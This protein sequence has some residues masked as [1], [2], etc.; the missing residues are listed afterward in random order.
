MLVGSADTDKRGR[1]GTSVYTAAKAAVRA[2]ARP[3]SVELLPRRIRVNV[4]SL[5]MTDVLSRE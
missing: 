3:M 1:I 4:L 2:L 5:A